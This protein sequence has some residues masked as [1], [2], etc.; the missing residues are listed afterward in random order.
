M[1]TIIKNGTIVTG[2]DV[3]KADVKIDNGTISEI[4]Q[5]LNPEPNDRVIDA[6]NQ[7]VFPGGIDVHTHLDLPGTVD[8]FESGTKAA[9]HGGITSIINYTNPVEGQSILENIKY[10]K[11]KAKDSYID[12]GFHSI[13]DTSNDA[14]INDLEKLA[15][16]EGVS[17]IKLFMANQD[18]NV[19]MDDA[20]LY[21]IMKRSAELGI[22]V[23]IHAENGVIIDQLVKEAVEQGNT[24]P[25]Y[26]AY[27]RPAILEAE[28]IS[29]VLMFSEMLNMP[30]Y[31][32]HVSSEEALKQ[33]ELA[34]QRNL[35]VIAE[36]CPQY[37]VLDESYL[38]KPNDEGVK[39]ICS[40]P[41]RKKKDQNKLWE[42]IANNIISTRSEERRVGKETRVQTCAHP[43]LSSEEDLK[44][45]ELAKQRNIPV[46]AE[47][48]PQYL[49]LDES[50]LEKPNEEGVKYICSPPLRKKKDQNKL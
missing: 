10:W 17:S 45:I 8:N 1:S 43:I 26:H 11:E 30:I 37:L 35:P 32:V 6:S 19:V 46:I 50:Y 41:L 21:R 39:Y 49:V 18:K 14:L 47:T 40:P 20:D 16:E 36:T 34:K 22:L 4:S 23:N 15:N 27:T 3:Y 9:A 31:I 38:E 7:Y 29:R 25:I 12:Y 42:G 5:S 28:A 13:I 44:Q 33:I 48:C 24:S 2:S